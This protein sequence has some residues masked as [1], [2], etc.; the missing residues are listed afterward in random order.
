M[1]KFGKGLNSNFAAMAAAMLMNISPRR[2]DLAEAIRREEDSGD[3]DGHDGEVHLSYLDDTEFRV[4]EEPLDWGKEKALGHVKNRLT[5]LEG[6]C[7][8]YDPREHLCDDG[9]LGGQPEE[10]WDDV[11]Y[12]KNVST[13]NS[14][15]E[16]GRYD[17]T[18]HVD[19]LDNENPEFDPADFLVNENDTVLEGQGV[20]G[21]I[22][23]NCYDP[24]NPLCDLCPHGN[25]EGVLV[26]LY[27]MPKGSCDDEPSN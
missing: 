10:G 11:F 19:C 8:I 6:Q 25:I 5:G 12:T 21:Q 23:S 20:V 9:P 14:D 15:A 16:S 24:M 18:D 1:G 13:S 26:V 3:G 7:D 17:H 2:D 22:L 4:S 27:E